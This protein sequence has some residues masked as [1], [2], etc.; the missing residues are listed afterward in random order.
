ML[1]KVAFT[2]SIYLGSD[3]GTAE[4]ILVLVV[5]VKPVSMSYG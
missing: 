5:A 3:I 1:Q 4:I 2:G